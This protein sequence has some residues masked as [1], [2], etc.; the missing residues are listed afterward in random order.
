M[1]I[2]QQPKV[3]MHA[4]KSSADPVASQGA[5]RATEE[6]PGSAAPSERPRNDAEVVPR[7]RRRQFSDA[8]HHLV[9][10][11]ADHVPPSDFDSGLAG[12]EHKDSSA[13]A[14]ASCAFF[15]L[16]RLCPEAGDKARFWRAAVNALQS[17]VQAPYFSSSPSQA[18][19]A[20]CA[21]RPATSRPTPATA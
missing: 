14:L 10:L 16:S 3:L 2:N 13:A 7:A 12:L 11:P 1:T 6:A 20:R 8:G 5:R 9:R 21:T 18:M 4:V 19:P 15:R 17:L